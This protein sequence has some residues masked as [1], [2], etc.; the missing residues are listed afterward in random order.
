M[1]RRRR[2]PGLGGLAVRVLSA[3]LVF[4]V[5]LI[6]T[7]AGVLAFGQ[8]A[9]KARIASAVQRR[10]GR[11]LVIA[12][13]LSIRPGLS[14]AFSAEDVSLA[15]L[16]GGSRP[17]M[18]RASRV[19]ARVAW[20][21]LLGGTVEVER[22]ALVRPDI[23]LERTADG[24]PNWRFEPARPAA[25]SGAVGSNAPRMNVQWRKLEVRDGVLAWLGGR[26][27]VPRLSLAPISNAAPVQV[28][29]DLSVPGADLHVAGEVGATTRLT[30]ENAWVHASL[31]GTVAR[32]RDFA[33]Y[34]LALAAAAPDLAQFSGVVGL[35]LPGLRDIG[36]SARIADRDGT[37]PDVTD[38]KLHAGA[39]DFAASGTAPL[40]IESLDVGAPSLRLP[41]AARL[42]GSLAGMPL[43]ATATLGAPAVLFAPSGAFPI[44]IA[45]DAAGGTL[46]ATGRI[47]NPG[48]LSGLDV[49]VTA[50]VPDLAALSPLAGRRL[51]ALSGVVVTGHLADGA[52]GFAHGV[53]LRHLALKAAA[54]DLAGD[55]A[56]TFGSRPA[57]EAQLT[58]DRLDID[59][60]LA[61]WRQP[62]PAGPPPS[63]TPP[64]S[65]Q[66]P[67]SEAPSVRV[68]PDLKLPLP[69]LDRA[70]LDL[71]LSVAILHLAGIDLHDYGGRLLLSHGVLTVDPFG[72]GIAD[73][74]LEA[75]AHAEADGAAPPLSITVH[76]AGVA[77]KPL[78]AAVGI[79]DDVAATGD[80]VAVLNGRGTTLREVAGSLD[81]RAS[82]AL[83]DGEIDNAT[84]AAWVGG[85][86][87]AAHVPAE[88]GTG[89]T[90]IR[91]LALDLEAARGDVAVAT[92]LL[93]TSRVTVQGS[94]DVN[95][96]DERLGL[97]FRPV[98]R[99]GGNNVAVPV[100][101]GGTLREPKV[102]VDAGGAL[103]SLLAGERRA[104][105]DACPA[106]LAMARRP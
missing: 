28:D 97:R 62:A 72:V 50:N 69:D 54:G 1:A 44:D 71:R 37:A 85:V 98:L 92:L 73:G 57:L 101:V 91:C 47:A 89:K 23:L 64:P 60:L 81:G 106:A 96:G 33:G 105:A 61:A 22:V 26:V 88:F 21:P 58:S 83:A 29:G 45:A 78:L 34:D 74:R 104:P 15:N 79:S 63:A 43:Q 35:A 19:E 67:P 5:V 36:L 11:A 90:S 10:T 65:S 102:G 14:L 20:L 49:A 99:F 42:A 76:G 95:L 38:L 31:I 39:S 84:L 4:V 87:R 68:I 53:A 30:F 40:H 70:D 75:T 48:A 2:Q 8:D 100:R 7:G 3:V 27:A 59:A 77:L 93:D 56:M 32:L 103:G 16:P 80:L 46:S 25:Q 6:A 94:G 13:P 24:T 66:A 41:L 82:L 17:D 86:L 12:G 9:I 51:P 52:G 55:A 18:A